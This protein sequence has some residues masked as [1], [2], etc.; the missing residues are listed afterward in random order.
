MPK[1]YPGANTGIYLIGWV[2]VGD[3]K[4]VW[5]LTYTVAGLF[6]GNTITLTASI[7][8][9]VDPNCSCAPGSI[10]YQ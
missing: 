9:S 4:G 8:F 2:N 3:T 1:V 5:T 7:Q 6:Q 10:T